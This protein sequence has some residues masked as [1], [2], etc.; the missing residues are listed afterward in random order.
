MK[1]FSLALE[2]ITDVIDEK[3]YYSVNMENPSNEELVLILKNEHMKFTSL[4]SKDH[5]EFTKL[6][7]H[8]FSENY[9][10]I[11][12][13]SCN[14]DRVLKSFKLNGK[15]FKKDTTFPCAAAMRW[16]L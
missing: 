6:R 4:G 8:L 16:Q 3:I 10:N 2:Y 7:E 13:N 5:P 15:V 9:I 11:D 14:R 1:N 12:R